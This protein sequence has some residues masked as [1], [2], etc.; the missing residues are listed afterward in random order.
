MNLENIKAEQQT[1]LAFLKAWPNTKAC[2]LPLTAIN[3]FSGEHHNVVA[4]FTRM[5][6]KGVLTP[7]LGSR[8]SAAM[9]C[10]GSVSDD[11][12]HRLL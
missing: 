4:C 3:A 6:G 10:W 9:C 1:C 5:F 2:A 12:T 11:P 7:A 8:L